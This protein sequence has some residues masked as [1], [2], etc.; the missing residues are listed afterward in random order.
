ME[1]F[2]LK[3][4]LEVGGPGLVLLAAGRWVQCECPLHPSR[5]ACTRRLP[6]LLCLTRRC[7]ARSTPTSTR[8]LPRLPPTCPQMLLLQEGAFDPA[9]GYIEYE[10]PE[11]DDAWL[12]SLE[13]GAAAG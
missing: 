10:R 9:G 7:P 3:R 13:G 2:H 5:R 4:E 8:L 6:L 12:D 1:P 11:Q